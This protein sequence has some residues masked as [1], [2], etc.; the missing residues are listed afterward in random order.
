MWGG[1]QNRLPHSFNGSFY[2]VVLSLHGRMCV[3]NYFKKKGYL[4]HDV[5]YVS[6]VPAAVLPVVPSRAPVHVAVEPAPAAAAVLKQQQLATGLQQHAGLLQHLRITTAGH[7]ERAKSRPSNDVVSDNVS[8]HQLTQ[9]DMNSSVQR[10][11]RKEGLRCLAVEPAPAAAAVL[12]LQQLATGLQQLA[13]LLQHLR[14]SRHQSYTA[15]TDVNCHQ[16]TQK[17]TLVLLQILRIRT[18]GHEERWST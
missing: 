8:C 13:G 12:K 14:K 1:G 11:R 9:P 17:Y 16:I 3:T 6:V 4:L 18:A 15:S 7:A 2:D 10:K 5:Q